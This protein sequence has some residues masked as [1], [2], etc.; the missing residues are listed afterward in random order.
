MWILKAWGWQQFRDTGRHA[1]KASTTKVKLTSKRARTKGTMLACCFPVP[2]RFQCQSSPLLSSLTL[3]VLVLSS[4]RK[5]IKLCIK[6]RMKGRYEAVRVPHARV[7]SWRWQEGYWKNVQRSLVSIWC[8]LLHVR[9]ERNKI[10]SWF[11]IKR[12]WCIT[13]QWIISR[14]RELFL[15]FHSLLL[16]HQEW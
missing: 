11:Y 10:C 13:S 15:K 3:C 7:W 2:G 16:C 9:R 1:G 6:G 5:S 14:K 12:R 8:V 4:H